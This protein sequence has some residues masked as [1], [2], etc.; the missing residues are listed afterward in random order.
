MELNACLVF[1][2][3]TEIIFLMILSRADIKI[4]DC[5]LILRLLNHH[6]IASTR[7]NNNDG[8]SCCIAQRYFLI[9][10]LQLSFFI[11]SN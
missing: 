9:A 10:K 3:V 2:S 5:L 8:I 1:K 7:Q 4:V 11:A 6:N